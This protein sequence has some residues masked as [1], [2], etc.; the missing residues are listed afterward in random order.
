VSNQF[1]K[2]INR[3]KAGT[4]GRSIVYY[5]FR[6]KIQSTVSVLV[7]IAASRLAL[8][9]NFL[10]PPIAIGK[11]IQRLCFI[12]NSISMNDKGFE[13]SSR[14]N[15]LLSRV[16]SFL[17]QIREANRAALMEPQQS[18]LLYQEEADEDE[19]K[20]DE[21][22][23]NE[24]SRFIYEIDH[25]NDS[26][27]RRSDLR[28]ETDGEINPEAISND[29]SEKYDDDDNLGMRND[30][31]KRKS[32]T[33][34]PIIVMDLHFGQDTDH[35]L[36]RFLCEKNDVDNDTTDII[37]HHNPDVLPLQLPNEQSKRCRRPRISVIS[38]TSIDQS[39]VPSSCFSN[40]G[41]S[42]ACKK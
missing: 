40:S 27:T 15:E 14:T 16:S 30:S 37:N 24:S 31:K 38:D 42:K 10:Q 36:F 19:T 8:C 23:D 12:R 35:P 18:L 2:A 5:H 1:V 28:I 25:Y 22:D 13:T 39:S 34:N 29:G 33:Q 26:L 7:L 32:E 3:C 11:R 17:P 4:T 41:N 20:D 6:L 21:S 9:Y